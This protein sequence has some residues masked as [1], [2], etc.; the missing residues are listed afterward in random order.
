MLEDMAVDQQNL[1][2]YQDQQ[3]QE[4]AHDPDSH[5]HHHHHQEEHQVEHR[6]DPLSLQDELQE[7]H[8]S[9]L[10]QDL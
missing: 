8:Y 1:I 2:L 5:H 9:D 3:R 7:L 6:Q 10:L 4:T